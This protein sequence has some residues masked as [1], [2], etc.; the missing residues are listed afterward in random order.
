MTV[1]NTVYKNLV[2]AKKKAPD[3]RPHSSIAQFNPTEW[4]ILTSS[5][6]NPT[7]MHWILIWPQIWNVKKEE[8]VPIQIK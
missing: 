7:E 2:W 5:C 1:K 4:L 6:K 8:K 3:M